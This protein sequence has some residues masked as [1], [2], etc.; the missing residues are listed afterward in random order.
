M[1]VLLLT[2]HVPPVT[3]SVKV[4]NAL[5]QTVNEPDITPALGAA[6]ITTVWVATSVPQ[7]LVTAYMI[8]SM[9]AVTP[10]TVVPATL[11]LVL[12]ALQVPPVAVDDKVMVAVSQTE[13]GPEIVPACGT[14]LTVIG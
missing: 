3:D 1:A 7:V 8:V 12:D 10:V 2:D 14:A 5:S 6:L 13:I 9:P 4:V 11:A